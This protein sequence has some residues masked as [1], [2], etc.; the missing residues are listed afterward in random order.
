MPKTW[1]APSDRLHVSVASQ[2]ENAQPKL[3]G[4][5]SK[6]VQFVASQILYIHTIQLWVS[7][8]R[9]NPVILLNKY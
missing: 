1:M 4:D 7:L 2:P 8:G 3:Q 9:L 5:M 6:H